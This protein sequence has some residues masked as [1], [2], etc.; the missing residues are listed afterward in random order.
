MVIGRLDTDTLHYTVFN[1][2][3][4]KSFIHVRIASEETV[5]IHLRKAQ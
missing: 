4:V 5:K 3:R 1:A 2:R